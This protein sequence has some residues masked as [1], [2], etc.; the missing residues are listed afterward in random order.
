MA[1]LTHEAELLAMM[2]ALYAEDE[3][4]SEVDRGRF[5]MTIKTLIAE[6]ARGR[7]VLFM[8]GLAV[9]GYALLIPFWS[10][11]FGGNLV[12][13]DELFVKP[14]FRNQGI[15]RAFIE[16]I[17]RQHPFEAVAAVLEVS[18]SNKRARRLYE[19]IG[20]R[21]RRNRTFTLRF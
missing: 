19:S 3:P 1:D 18:P 20:F 9:R 13:I 5:P 12:F 4:A 16:F 6:P 10:N 11:E 17:L 8:E 14:E 21:L 15:G 2:N 7:I